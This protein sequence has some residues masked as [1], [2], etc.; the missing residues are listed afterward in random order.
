[1]VFGPIGAARNHFT[2]PCQGSWAFIALWPPPP[3]R[4][5]DQGQRLAGGNPVLCR[6]GLD[7][8]EGPFL[9]PTSEDG[10]R[11]QHGQM[12]RSVGFQSVSRSQPMSSNAVPVSHAAP[13]LVLWESPHIFQPGAL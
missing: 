1:M 10:F 6:D 5:L 12:T 2:W 7:A 11:W 13:T 8:L 3:W 4:A 9:Q